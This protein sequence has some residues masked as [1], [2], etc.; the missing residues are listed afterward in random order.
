MTHVC[1]MFNL[2]NLGILMIQ[3]FVQEPSYREMQLKVLYTEM[4]SMKQ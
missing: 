2:I 3:L 1:H 4:K